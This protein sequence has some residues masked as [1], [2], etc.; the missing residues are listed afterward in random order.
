MTYGDAVRLLPWIRHFLVQ[1]KL[2][3]SRHLTIGLVI[4]EYFDIGCGIAGPIGWHIVASRRGVFISII[5]IIDWTFFR[6]G[7]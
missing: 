2:V 7:P 1:Q 3:E 5:K 6:E 4:H